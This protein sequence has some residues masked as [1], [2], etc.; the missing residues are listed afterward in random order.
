MAA[1][2]VAGLLAPLGAPGPDAAPA[3]A[4]TVGE[5]VGQRFVVAMGGTSPSSSLL[6]RVA[7]GEIGGVIL[8]GGNVRS[9]AQVR[10]LTTRLQEAARSAGR[11]PVIVAVDQ[12]GGGIRR[13]RWVGPAA[14]TSQLGRLPAER[15]RA[16]GRAAGLGL[17]AAGVDL[18]L[19]PVADVPIAG[20][21]MAAEARTFSSDPGVVGDRVAAFAAGLRSAR[22]AAAVK[23]FPG[24]GRARQNTDRSAVTIES[25]APALER[26]LAPFRAAIDGGVPVVMVSNAAYTAYGGGPATWAPAIQA[27]LRRDLGFE[28][29]T[30]TDALEGAASTRGR[31]LRSVTALAIQAGVDLVLLTGSE[32][33]S[34][35]AYAHVVALVEA[36]RIPLPALRRS[37]ERIAALKADVR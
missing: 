13:L 32:R 10:A 8:F 15:V 27:L 37:A 30:I 22:V 35:D 21:F 33:S 31:T 23:H 1:A 9:P 18:D 6:G 24:I 19:A 16:E 25:S 12:E 29:V 2:T 7:R 17:R 5:L 26:D 3:P 14:T 34:A 36:G 20:S 28:G 4:P 11:P